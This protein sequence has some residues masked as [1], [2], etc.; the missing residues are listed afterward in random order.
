MN[1]KQLSYD[2][3]DANTIIHEIKLALFSTFS[4]LKLF[5]Q[6]VYNQIHEDHSRL[7]SNDITEIISKSLGLSMV[8]PNEINTVEFIKYLE[9]LTRIL[10]SEISVF[11]L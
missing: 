8:L 5:L 2:L 3:S 1:E 9:N 7:F 4:I 6:K 11:N 10:L